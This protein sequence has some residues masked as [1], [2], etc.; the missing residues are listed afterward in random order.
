[1]SEDTKKFDLNPIEQQ[2]IGVINDQHMSMLSNFFSFIALE[3]LNYK[4]TE[5][6]QFR[7]EEGGRLHIWEY[8]PEKPPVDV[9]GAGVSTDK[10]DV[11]DVAGGDAASALK[12]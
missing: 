6:T 2:M 7:L 3:R 8:T 4:V 11:A 1:M 10:P 9:A 5:F 12:A